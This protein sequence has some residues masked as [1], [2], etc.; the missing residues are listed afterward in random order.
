MQIPSAWTR[1]YVKQLFFAV[2]RVFGLGN[3][4]PKALNGG[5]CG[6]C[7]QDDRLVSCRPFA[8]DPATVRETSSGECAGPESARRS[9]QASRESS[10]DVVAM[11]EASFLSQE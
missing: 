2:Y 6:G 9:G 7:W 3:G 8:A 4:D 5:T 1:Q 11:F 10:V